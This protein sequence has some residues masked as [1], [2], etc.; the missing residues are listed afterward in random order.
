MSGTA[1]E[2]V[3]ID[4]DRRRAEGHVQ[5]LRDAAV[6]ATGARV[7]AGGFG[8]CCSADVTIITTGVSQSSVQSRLDGLKETAAILKGLVQDIA[9]HNP[10][11]ILLIASNPVDV[12]TY[13]AWRW[14]G[15]P[16]SQVIGSGT[17]LDT[18]RFRQRFARGYGVA[19]DNVHAHIIGEH[20][21]SQVP[22]LSSAQVAGV[23]LH[24]FSQQLGLGYEENVLGNIVAETRTAGQ[25]IIT[26]KGATYYGIAAALVRIVRAILRDENA[27]LTVSSLVPKSMALGEV[28]LSL[29]ATVNRD[30]IARVM[31][32]PLSPSEWRAL[33]ASADILKTHIA[34]LDFSEAT[35]ASANRNLREAVQEVQ[36]EIQ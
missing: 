15:L 4:R 3:L 28:S 20:G 34:Q 33:R 29:A 22:V 36:H 10:N 6:F 5:D 26:A 21:D 24:R 11:G 31:P 23:P 13:A 18:A 35:T 25:E 7:F 9:Q 19:S 2:I 14:S 27:V 8:D 16:A 30:G 12:L 17:A 1:A 32:I